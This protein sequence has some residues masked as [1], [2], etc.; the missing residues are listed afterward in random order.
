[1]TKSKQDLIKLLR[2]TI[3]AE[4]AD[5][6]VSVQPI[7]ISMEDLNTACNVLAALHNHNHPGDNWSTNLVVVPKDPAP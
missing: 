7:N 6:L 3:P 2:K 4:V 1:M 5:A